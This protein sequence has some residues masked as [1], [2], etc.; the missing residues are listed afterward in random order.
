L[1]DDVYG[2]H[3]PAAEL[4]AAAAELGSDVPFFLSGGTAL[5]EGRGERVTPL[6]DL[7]PRWLAL[8]NPGVPLSTA[9]VFREL[10]PAEY[11]SGEITRSYMLRAAEALALPLFNSLEAAAERLEPAIAACRRRMVSAGAGQVLLSGSGPT[12]FALAGDERH[13]THLAAAAGAL[14]SH[15]VPRPQSLQLSS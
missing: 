2:L 5:V 9:A 7:E 12:L 15:F 11:G 14:P 1:L 3:L 13:A 4:L 10:K 6:P 8:L